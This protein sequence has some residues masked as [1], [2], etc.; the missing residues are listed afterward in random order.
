MIYGV[1][2][3][4][5]IGKRTGLKIPKQY[6]E[7]LNK[8][9]I[10]YT[11]ESFLSFKE[12]DEIYIAVAKEWKPKVNEMINR[13]IKEE[14]AKRVFLVEGGSERVDT[15]INV[16]KY[17]IENKKINDED[18]IIFHDAVRPFISEDVIINSIECARKYGAAV[19]GVKAVDTMLRSEDGKKVDEILNRDQIYLG[20]SPDTFKLK[21]FIE[22]EQRLTDEQ[23]KQITGTSQ[24]ST[25]NN[26]P[27]YI[28]NS[29][30][31]NFKITTIEDMKKAISII[32][33]ND[34]K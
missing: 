29:N 33:G 8:P 25:F 28:S 17:I 5:G 30:D 19:A 18:I 26:E 22:L 1:I 15:I 20:Q 34:K 11:L 10:I 16:E 14:D 31:M 24:F 21:Y 7:I 12:I 2:L 13:F 23:K 3:A 9:I 6:I 32:K 4:G 27:I